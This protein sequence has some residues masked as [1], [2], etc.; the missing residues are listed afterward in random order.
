MQTTIHKNCNL[1]FSLFPPPPPFFSL[2]PS[3]PSSPPFG[4][5]KVPAPA[6][7]KSRGSVVG[8]YLNHELSPSVRRAKN[9]P[10]T[11]RQRKSNSM[12]IADPNLHPLHITLRN[13]RKQSTPFALTPP[14]IL[15]P[16]RHMSNLCNRHTLGIA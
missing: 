11:N 14:S 4:G 15:I 16:T 7:S 1:L 8:I 5:L 9:P 6:W 12:L 2:F 10:S 3:F 13:C